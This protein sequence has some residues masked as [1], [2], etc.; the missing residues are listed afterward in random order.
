MCAA[1][2]FRMLCCSIGY[3]LSSSS[4]QCQ[5]IVTAEVEAR[6]TAL[7][8]FSL[9]SA[10]SQQGPITQVEKLI[11]KLRHPIYELGL[12][13]ICWQTSSCERAGK[14]CGITASGGGGIH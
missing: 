8:T 3:S 7:E 1:F 13:Y 4:A 12:V 11:F 5:G 14:G 10:L 9:P 6:S 2:L